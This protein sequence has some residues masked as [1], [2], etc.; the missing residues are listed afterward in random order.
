MRVTR[1]PAVILALLASA[2]PAAAQ[3]Q[4]PA[5]PQIASLDSDAPAGSPPHWLPGEQWVMQHWLP[6]D[7]ERLYSLLGVDRGVVWRQLRDDT[8]TLAQL[9]Q[10]HGWEPQAL[11]HELVAPW[12]GQLRDPARLALLEKRA[13]RTLTQ[14]HLSQHLFF[15][16]LHQEAIPT[17]ATAIFGVASR[18][19]WSTLRRSE[20]SPLQICRLNGLPRGHAQEQAAATLREY[21]AK[22]VARQSIPA[23]QARR[24][25]SRQLRQLP[26]WLQQTRYNGPPPLVSP[27]SSP[28]TASNYSNNAALSND[29]REV[30]FESYQAKLAIAKRLGEIAVMARTVGAAAPPALA[31]GEAADP[32]SNYNPALSANGRWVA[33]ESALGNLNFA[34]RY[35]RMEVLARDL[36]SGR[37][38]RVSHPPDL[39]VSR[40][41]YNPTISGDGRLIAYEAY[42]RPDRPDGGTRVVVRDLRSGRERAVPAPAGMA[43][44][45]YEPRLSADGRHLAFSALARATGKRSEVFVRDLRSGRTRRASGAGEEAWEPVLSAHGTVVAY[46]AAGAGGESHVVVR[47]LVRGTVAAIASPAGSGLAFEPSLSSTG[48]RVAFVARPGG[49]RQTQ[50]FVHDVRARRTQLVSRADGLDGPPGMGSAS[51]PA[52]SGDG[53]RVAFTSEAWNLSPQKC[54]S[55]RG[56]FVRDLARTTTRPASAGDGGNRY[57][58]PTKGSSTESDAFITLLCA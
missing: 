28:A 42:D 47:D 49:T 3:V 2:T 8:R 17:H 51:H 58:G 12:R 46:T 24:L 57:L 22:G 13:L 9:A 19:E 11:A 30:V 6:Y 37:T 45:V 43:G 31:S 15:H 16:S 40:S 36:R 53:R 23:A 44:E 21:A 10:E 5:K 26:R 54:N 4:L 1:M 14:G 32:R 34:K 20:L 48:R 50:V 33:F 35:G 56:I 41:A 29:G 39:T 38:I 25:L 52:I 27:R 7:E 55:A 18:A